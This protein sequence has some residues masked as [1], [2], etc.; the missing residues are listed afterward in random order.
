MAKQG[1]PILEFSDKLY[2]ILDE[3][4]DAVSK[5]L[6]NLES[7][8]L[9]TQALNNLQISLVDVSKSDWS[10]DV[11]ISGKVEVMKVGKFLRYYLPKKFVEKEMYD[12]AAKYNRVKN[13]VKDLSPPP[14]GKKYMTVGDFD[15][16]FPSRKPVVH[17][18]EIEV[19][20]FKFDP[21]DIRA[22]FISL[23]TETYPHGHEEEVIPYIKDIGLQKDEFGNYYKIVGNST[24]MFTSHLDTASREK[25]KISL[26]SEKRNGDEIISSDG[27]TILGADDKSGMTILLYMIANKVPGVYY[28]FIGEERGGIG[29]S[30]VSSIFDTLEHLK[31]MKR[32][33][34]F[35]RRNYYS[36]ITEQ[37]GL[38]CCSDEFAHAL[39][40]EYGKLGMT[41]RLDDTGVYTD[42]AEF[43]D[44]I[45]ECT[46]ISV[47]YFDEHRNNEEQN[48]TFLIK[49]AK[50]SAA[51]NWEA[52]PASKKVGVDEAI[53][54]K[55]SGFLEDLKEC[56]FNTS[57]KLM[58]IH[59]RTYLRIEMDEPSATLVFDDLQNISYLLDKYNMHPSIFFEDEFIK[60]ELK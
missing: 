58:T 38:R 59:T 50:A 40:A 57:M 44:H 56:A 28:F 60:I 36:I 11:T 29:S 35:D 9:S 34:A 6:I 51:I 27:R 41:Y 47:G 54:R 12:F 32:C 22:T 20:P 48:M 26:R 25:S 7:N 3:V 15:S 24:S 8:S 43:I 46:N 19:P 23:V 31:G 5:A 14:Q 13:G 2:V 37:M 55:H 10:F 53:L 45:P 4:D 1:N 52:L 49:L 18:D 30:K 33:V 42:S 16:F 39:S 21:M 17:K